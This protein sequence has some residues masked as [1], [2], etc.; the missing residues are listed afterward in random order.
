MMHDTLL[1]IEQDLDEARRNALVAKLSTL[2]GG[3]VHHHSEKPHLIFVP[4]NPEL[5]AI[6]LMDAVRSEGISAQIIDF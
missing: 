1:H 2:T 4:Y 3:E 6:G 5:G